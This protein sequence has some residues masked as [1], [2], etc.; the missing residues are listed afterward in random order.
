MIDKRKARRLLIGRLCIVRFAALA[1]LALLPFAGTSLLSYPD[2]MLLAYILL[3]T[4]FRQARSE[5]QSNV[6]AENKTKK[7]AKKEALLRESLDRVMAKTSLRHRPHIGLSRWSFNHYSVGVCGVDLP[8]LCSIR[9]GR[10]ITRLL[11]SKELDAVLYHELAHIKHGDCFT[12]AVS[13][14]TVRSLGALSWH[15]EK[16]WNFSH[17]SRIIR[18]IK[19]LTHAAG[20][21]MR[22]AEFAADISAAINMGESKTLIS[23]LCKL[24]EVEKVSK[25]TGCTTHPSTASRKKALEKLEAL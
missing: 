19:T 25:H 8:G 1:P 15:L 24:A 22:Q 3:W 10:K 18:S 5:F 11:N 6:R 21:C 14:L 13:A 9:V 12:L 7:K 16:R 4:P 17:D 20:A 23:A 2:I